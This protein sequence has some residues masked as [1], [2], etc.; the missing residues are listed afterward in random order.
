MICEQVR[1]PLLEVRE[2]HLPGSPNIVDVQPNAT[3]GF[4]DHGTALERVVDAFNAV[5]FHGDEEAAR[6]LRV[7]C[8][9]V[10]ERGGC[11]REVTFRHHVVRLEDVLEVRTV[12]TNG[13]PHEQVL[14]TLGHAAIDTEK[15]GSLQRLETEA[16]RS[17]LGVRETE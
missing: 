3:S 1:F 4:A 9:G 5:V 7:R 12:D 10:E 17:G 13:D 11:V 16:K 14:R 6:H 15:V 2:K 8:A